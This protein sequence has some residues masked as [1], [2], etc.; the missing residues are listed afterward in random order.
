[1]TAELSL[2]LVGAQVLL[3]EGLLEAELS[4]RGG[5]ICDVAGVRKIDLSGYLVLPGIVDVH[6]DGFERHLAPRRGAMK[7]MA[8]GIVAAEAELAANGITT[9][10]LAQFLSWA[11]ESY[12]RLC[13]LLP[14]VL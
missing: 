4:V 12:L 11:T 13:V 8:E 1:M 6:G 10:V 5:L 9:G 14:L 3:A 7:Q 2:N